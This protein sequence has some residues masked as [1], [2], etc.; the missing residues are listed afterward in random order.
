M[1]GHAVLDVFRIQNLKD[2][3]KGPILSHCKSLHEE[4]VSQVV[5]ANVLRVPT[6]N[7]EFTVGADGNR[8]EMLVARGIFGSDSLFSKAASSNVIFA[9][10]NAN[11]IPFSSLPHVHLTAQSC[12]YYVFIVR[13]EIY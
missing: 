7:D 13:M 10:N 8:V 2:S 4:L 6:T 11:E 3:I 5:K 12:G 9:I 1:F